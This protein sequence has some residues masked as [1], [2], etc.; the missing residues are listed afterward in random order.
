MCQVVPFI[1]SCCGHRY[2]KVTKVPSCDDRWPK[3]KCA[4]ELCILITK[5]EKLD[6]V[7]WR[8]QAERAGLLGQD[9]DQHRPGLDHAEVTKGLNMDI[10]G[11]RRLVEE[12]GHC[13]FCNAASGCGTCGA[14]IIVAGYADYNRDV[15][16]P[17]PVQKAKGKRKAT[18]FA[19]DARRE[20]TG[21]GRVLRSKRVKVEH[22]QAQQPIQHQFVPGHDVGSSHQQ[23][24]SVMAQGQEQGYPNWLVQNSSASNFLDRGTSLNLPRDGSPQPHDYNGESSSAF[25]VYENPENQDS[26]ATY[27]S[28]NVGQISSNS[29][30]NS[31]MYMSEHD[32]SSEA[33]HQ[34]LAYKAKLENSP[35]PSQFTYPV[36]QDVG[37][38]Q[39]WK[40]MPPAQLVNG[41]RQSGRNYEQLDNYGSTDYGYDADS[42]IHPAFLPGVA[43]YA[44]QGIF[45]PQA[46]YGPQEGYQPQEGYEPQGGYGAVQ[47]EQETQV[48]LDPAMQ[49]P[50][51][52]PV[53]TAQEHDG[54]EAI[55]PSLAWNKWEGGAHNGEENTF[56]QVSFEQ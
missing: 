5:I 50:Q 41:V 19:Q 46:D 28:G 40:S 47:E 48:K 44:T 14:G 42:N 33:A 31:Y 17:E 15:D 20:A 1:A 4:P 8:C 52:Q 7:C 54:E 27:E 3:A 13:W 22:A 6:V 11:R 56:D 34:Y 25:D 43:D 9:R 38:H 23:G 16:T 12:G 21:E 18:G 55:D 32:T 39:R 2:V 29:F 10:A 51:Y 45:E 53:M 26:I 36:Y 30:P 24:S 35:A 49:N 37:P